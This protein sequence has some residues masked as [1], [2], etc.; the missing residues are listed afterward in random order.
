MIASWRRGLLSYV[1]RFWRIESGGQRPVN[2]RW[3][4]FPCEDLALSVSQ[5]SCFL[6]YPKSELLSSII[7]AGTLRLKYANVFLEPSM[8]PI[9]QEFKI[10]LGKTAIITQSRA[11]HIKASFAVTSAE[12]SNRRLLGPPKSK[13]LCSQMKLSIHF[14]DGGR[15]YGWKNGTNPEGQLRKEA[16]AT[17]GSGSCSRD[18]PRTAAT[19]GGPRWREAHWAAGAPQSQ[20]A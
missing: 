9:N 18:I 10:A 5:V 4:A 16:S 7:G 8:G 17:Q 20:P 3:S 1:S 19:K 13:H 2:A 14:R 15:G 11:K 12:L 6:L